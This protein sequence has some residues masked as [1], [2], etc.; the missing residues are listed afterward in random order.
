M[1]SHW[2]CVRLRAG[3]ASC[4][5][6]TR[7]TLREVRFTHSGQLG[8]MTRQSACLHE[9]KRTR[10]ACCIASPQRAPIV[11]I[12]LVH[13][14]Q[15]P[16]IRLPGRTCTHAH[17]MIVRAGNDDLEIQVRSEYRVVAMAMRM[18]D[19]CTKS[20]LPRCVCCRDCI[21]RKCTGVLAVT[22]RYD[23]TRLAARTSSAPQSRLRAA[24]RNDTAARDGAALRDQLWCC[25]KW[26]D[27]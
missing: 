7:R 4:R 17:S 23:R 1:L 24:D 10:D 2:K 21:A 26:R 6:P 12:G 22:T 20:G 18:A 15:G 19:S 11:P 3:R 27:T 9:G 8:S 13:A 16:L 25:S 14:E 5:N